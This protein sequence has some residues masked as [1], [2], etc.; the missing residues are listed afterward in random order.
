[1]E[2]KY[3][4]QYK[5]GEIYYVDF[6]NQ[7]GAVVC[8][9]HPAMIV[10]SDLGNRHSPTIIV[11]AISTG[12]TNI[13]QITHIELCGRF[14]LHKESVLLLEQLLTDDKAMIHQRLGKASPDLLRTADYALVASLGLQPLMKVKKKRKPKNPPLPPS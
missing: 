1:M 7:P 10:Q 12:I 5:R 9:M 8:G 11:A 2:H 14:G 13:R 4:R 3:F 6:G